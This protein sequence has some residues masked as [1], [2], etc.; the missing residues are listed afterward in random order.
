VSPRKIT[1]MAVM[2][3][4]TVRNNNQIDYSITKLHW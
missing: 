1:H 2:I 3:A 4:P